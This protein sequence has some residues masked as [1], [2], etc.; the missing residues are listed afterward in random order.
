MKNLAFNTVLL[1]LL[2][3]MSACEQE[4]ADVSLQYRLSNGDS[5]T[6]KL[7]STTDTQ[8]PNCSKDDILILNFNG[9][10]E[11][12]SGPIKCDAFEPNILNESPVQWFA[13]EQDNKLILVNI[14]RFTEIVSD[15]DGEN[16][17]EIERT[18]SNGRSYDVL[19]VS[20][21]SLLLQA[22]AQSAFG[23][24]NDFFSYLYIAN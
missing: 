23:Q 18:V 8:M 1:L 13:L 20:A 15:R 14:E 5:K 11:R 7:V 3:F 16:P 4:E 6:W 24:R 22:K 12:R 21:D 9:T 19:A 2:G 10:A 17:I